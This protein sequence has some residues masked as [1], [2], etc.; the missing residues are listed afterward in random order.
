[1]APNYTFWGGKKEIVMSRALIIIERHEVGDANHV[2]LH[3]DTICK[4]E[5]IP[6]AEIVCL[7]IDDILKITQRYIPKK[8]CTQFVLPLPLLPFLSFNEIQMLIYWSHLN[9]TRPNSPTLTKLLERYSHADALGVLVKMDSILN[10]W[11]IFSDT[12]M[13]EPQSRILFSFKE[14]LG[15]ET[16]LEIV[17]DTF[18][19]NRTILQ[20]VKRLDEYNQSTFLDNA[21]LLKENSVFNFNDPEFTSIASDLF[22]SIRVIKSCA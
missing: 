3:L 4:Q 12:L 18:F 22:E 15:S 6:K 5:D 21:A 20:F 16:Y 7:V 13:S 11:N 9:Y 1:M 2:F 14:I 10:T 8:I 17:K 19:E